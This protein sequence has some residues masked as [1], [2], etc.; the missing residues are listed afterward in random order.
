MMWGVG[1]IS[2]IRFPLIQIPTYFYLGCFEG[3]LNIVIATLR[4]VLWVALFWECFLLVLY[5][6]ISNF[7]FNYHFFM[8]LSLSHS[9]T[10][11]V[12]PAPAPCSPTP[13]SILPAICPQQKWRYF[14]SHLQSNAFCS[15]NQKS[16]LFRV[17]APK[18]SIH[19]FFF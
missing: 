4:P 2:N 19:L 10:K 17:K 14:V 5:Q 8:H 15:I 11:H 16:S 7:W 1:G 6:S 18:R 9:H 12:K 3:R 13:N